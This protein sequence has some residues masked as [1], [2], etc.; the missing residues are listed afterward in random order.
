MLYSNS[1]MMLVL[2][3]KCFFINIKAALMQLF[4][5]GRAAGLLTVPDF[6]DQT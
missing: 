2:I 1:I 5:F 3:S 4:L 6:S